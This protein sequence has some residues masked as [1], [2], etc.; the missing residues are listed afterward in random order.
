MN[1]FYDGSKNL[2][3]YDENWQ[4]VSEPEYPV[5]VDEYSRAEDSNAEDDEKDGK[6]AKPPKKQSANHQ[7]LLTIQLIV[8]LVIALAAFALKGIG[9]ELYETVRTVY[10]D[11]LNS[12]AVFE[13]GSGFD[14]NSFLSGAT[15]DEI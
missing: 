7:L 13:D 15:A 14:V 10:Y 11:A 5:L 6:K 4:N 9:G 12:Q 2:I 1:E 8:C 3:T